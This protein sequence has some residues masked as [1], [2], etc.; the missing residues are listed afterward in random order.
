MM[1]LLNIIIGIILI[2]IGAIFWW[3][4]WC[5]V[6]AAYW[7]TLPLYVTSACGITMP[8]KFGDKQIKCT[9][10]NGGC[11]AI[12]YLSENGQHQTKIV[13]AEDFTYEI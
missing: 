3:R 10:L 2:I 4:I 12:E 9:P 8:K 13:K 11:W 5:I 7:K 1:M 6:A